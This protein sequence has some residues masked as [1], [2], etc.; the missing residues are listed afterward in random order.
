MKFRY[1][2]IPALLLTLCALLSGCS[3]P[4]EEESVSLAVVAGIH[5]NA[6]AISKTSSSLYQAVYDTCAAYGDVTLV[7]CDGE[8]KAYFQGVIDP[9]DVKGLSDNRLRTRAQ[10]YTE[11][12]LAQ[13]DDAAA[14]VEEVDTL[15]AIHLA[16][17]S[18]YAADQKKM[19]VLDTGLCTTG[20]LN[21]TR[22]LLDAEPEA[23]AA[24]LEEANALPDLTGVSVTWSYLGQVADPQEPLSPAK[25]KKLEAIW[26]AVLQK[27]GAAEVTF[28]PDFTTGAANVGLPTVSLVETDGQDLSLELPQLDQTQVAF[29]GDTARFL[30]ADAASQAILE[31]ASYLEEHPSLE[32]YVVGTTASGAEAV[33][34]DLSQRRAQA[35][36]QVLRASG[37]AES[38]L[39]PLGLGF[40]DPWHVEDRDASGALVETL[41]RQNRRVLIL[42]R[43]S[44]EA[45]LLAPYL[46]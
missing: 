40:S 33:C 26:L 43:N 44:P 8:P 32:I 1:N 37:V 11:Q 31:V 19:L 9:P 29:V 10:S 14:V 21:F 22:G 13:L 30:D 36:C 4:P 27:A 6:G 18:L 17:Q 28:V 24:A 12:I 41:A 7:R 5:S 38:R 3:T 16:A 25:Q 42:D 39:T 35:V 46:F 45:E 20:Y 15:Q 2:A 34:R 23:V